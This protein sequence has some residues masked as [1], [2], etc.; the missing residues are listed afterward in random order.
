M[1]NTRRYLSLTRSGVFLTTWRVIVIAS[2]YRM[3]PGTGRGIHHHQR[4]LIAE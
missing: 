3:R 4:N 2:D 1:L